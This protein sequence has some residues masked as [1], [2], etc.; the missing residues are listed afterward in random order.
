MPD[1]SFVTRPIDTLLKASQDFPGADLEICT[2]YITSSGVLTL[3]TI[4]KSAGRTRAVIALIPSNRL[5]TFQLL[6]DYGVEVYLYPTAPYTLFHPKIYSGTLQAEAWAMIGSTNCTENGFFKNVEQN[7]FVSGQRHTEPFLSIESRISSFFTHA[8]RFD[9][10]LE[11]SLNKIQQSLGHNP[12]VNK[13]SRKLASFGITPKTATKPSI[14]DEVSTVA[15]ETLK[16]FTKTTR[17]EYAYQMLLLL[18]MLSHGNPD[19]FLSIEKAVEC[20][21]DFYK[22]RKL[23]GSIIEK[24]HD[25][26]PAPVVHNIDTIKKYKIKQMIKTSP[27]PRFERQGLLDLSEDGQCFIINPA[28]IA[29]L[30]PA[31][32]QELRAIAIRRLAEHFEDSE[33]NIQMLIKKTIG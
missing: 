25:A 20:F 24:I 13:F 21:M 3:Q 29:A 32:R 9:P 15:L 4:L 31:D 26:K 27:F 17:L 19:G 22:E 12:D 14:P 11:Q 5:N 7:L 18:I 16:N 1:T 30:T 10:S 6:Q 23:S 2:G 33:K 28:I 8:Y